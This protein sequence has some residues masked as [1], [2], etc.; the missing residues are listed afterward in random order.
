MWGWGGGA[1]PPPPPAPL[2]GCGVGFLG[3]W[4]A[5]PPP[6]HSGPLLAFDLFSVESSFNLR[7]KIL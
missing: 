1:P 5:P 2:V 4:G 6:P 3:G 7:D